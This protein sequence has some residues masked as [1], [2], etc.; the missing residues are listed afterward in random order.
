ML[1]PDKIA[2]SNYKS[3]M[4]GTLVDFD[5]NG[6]IIEF[7]LKSARFTKANI[8]NLYKTVNIYSFNYSSFEKFVVLVLH[9]LVKSSQKQVF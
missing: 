4:D 7:I 5:E 3:Y 2:V 1:L 6:N 8:H 9:Y